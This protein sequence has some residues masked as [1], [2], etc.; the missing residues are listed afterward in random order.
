MEM[1]S[2]KKLV[3]NQHRPMLNYTSKPKS[4]IREYGA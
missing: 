3:A 4:F 2:L 1:E